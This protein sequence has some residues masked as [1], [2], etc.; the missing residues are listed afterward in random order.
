MEE[1][2][3]LLDVSARQLLDSSNRRGN[4]SPD[5]VDGT[6]RAALKMHPVVARGDVVGAYNTAWGSR[7]LVTRRPGAW[8]ICLESSAAAIN[9]TS[10]TLEGRS[11]RHVLGAS[12]QPKGPSRPNRVTSE[13][14]RTVP[15]ASAVA[16]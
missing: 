10:E 15:A 16:A 13:V 6:M 2:P 7:S 5:L 9:R 4:L 8:Q 12:T 1:G 3:E 11:P 14:I